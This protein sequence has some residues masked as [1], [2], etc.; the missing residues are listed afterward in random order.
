MV[1]VHLASLSSLADRLCYSA[2]QKTNLFME[3]RD[4]LVKLI[5]KVENKGVGVVND[6]DVGDL[7]IMKTKDAPT[8]KKYWSKN[9]KRRCLNCN[10]IGHSIRKC[11]L[12]LSEQGQN[13]IDRDSS[14]ND[15]VNGNQDDKNIVSNNRV[16]QVRNVQPSSAQRNVN[17]P[18]YSYL[19]HVAFNPAIYT[20]PYMNQYHPFH[21]PQYPNANI[22]DNVPN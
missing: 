12:F 14:E 5:N 17:E 13:I 11:P 6:E 9:K 20:T 4:E 2:A 1:M 10:K 3:I 22:V 8:K 18:P 16:T 19:A 21:V 7:M 15:D